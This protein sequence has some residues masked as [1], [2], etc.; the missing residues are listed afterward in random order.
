MPFLREENPET[1]G[2]QIVSRCSPGTGWVVSREEIVPF[3]EGSDGG[4]NDNLPSCTWDTSIRLLTPKM[5][6]LSLSQMSKSRN[7][8][9]TLSIQ[10][11]D[12]YYLKAI[13]VAASRWLHLRVTEVFRRA[14][15][16]FGEIVPEHCSTRSFSRLPIIF[17]DSRLGSFVKDSKL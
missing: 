13:P 6:P 1:A 4:S 9:R 17:P 10:L 3:Q 15:G 16:F 5:R 11:C 7:R 12:T 2:R 8:A 14:L